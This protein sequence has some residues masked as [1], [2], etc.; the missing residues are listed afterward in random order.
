MKSTIEELL[1]TYKSFSDEKLIRLATTEVDGLRPEAIQVMREEVKRRRLPDGLLNGIEIQTKEISSDKLLAYCEL[2][3]RQPCPVCNTESTKL[4]AT[5]TVTVVSYLI[6]TSSE[7]LLVFACPN[8]LTKSTKEAM[9]KTA[10][11]GW[12]GFPSGIYLTIKALFHNS[13][14]S[15]QTQLSEPNEYFTNFVREQIG[16]IEANKTNPE[17]LQSLVRNLK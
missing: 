17:R 9:I 1:E 11:F 14:I 16:I 6:M 13:K 7:N 12:W 2:L 8:C 15:R 10:L 5:M 3:R 4:N